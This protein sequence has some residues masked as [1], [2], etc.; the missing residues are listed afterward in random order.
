MSVDLSTVKR[1]A[2]LSRIA[3]SE[4][5]AEAMVKDLNAILGFVD[6]LSEVNVDDV[7]PMTSAIDAQMPM[8]PDEVT[9]GDC[10]DSVLLNSPDQAKIN[11][12]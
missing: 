8:R 3:L 2:R 11:S 7:S 12:L 6:Q 1:I 9:D 10:P 4:S 5:H